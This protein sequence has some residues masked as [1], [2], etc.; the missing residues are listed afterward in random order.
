MV[1]AVALKKKVSGLGDFLSSGAF[2]V[3]TLMLVFT[4][5]AAMGALI[6]WPETFT[7]MASFAASFRIWCFG[8]DPMTGKFNVPQLALVVLDPVFF[9]LLI[10]GVWKNQIVESVRAS[11]VLLVK[12]GTFSALIVLSILTGVSYLDGKALEGKSVADYRLLR[13]SDPAPAIPLLDQNGASYSIKPGRVTIVSAFYAHC[14]HTCPMIVE[15]AKQALA[16]SGTLASP[17]DVAMITLD[18]ESDTLTALKEK[19]TALKLDAN[20]HLLTGEPKKVNSILDQYQVRRERAADG[21]IAH[22]NIFYVIDK[23]GSIAFRIGLG[24]A[25]EAWLRKVLKLLTSEGV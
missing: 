8:Y 24:S 18:P 25:Q 19:S 15:Q 7:P 10:G 5:T 12:A 16:K 2:G 9:A 3:F 1:G 20:W 14:V 11:K 21:T 13:T 23:K 6:L 17:V 4:W 22:S